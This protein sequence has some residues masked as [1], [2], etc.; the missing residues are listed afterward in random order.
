MTLKLGLLAFW[1]AWFAVVAA[2]NACGALKAL[3]KLPASWRFVS[4]NYEAIVKATAMYAPPRWLPAL[5]FAG[6]IAWQLAAFAL[7]ACALAGSLLAGAIDLR[8]ATIALAAGIALWAAF[9]LAD[10]ITVKYEFERTH[11]LLF[12]AQLATLVALHILPD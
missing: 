3:G 7:L 1:M 6:V 9:M 11:E 12:I 4:A 10:E 5:L 8:A 2:T